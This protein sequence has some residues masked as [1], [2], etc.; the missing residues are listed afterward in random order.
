MSIRCD[1]Q[2]LL[3]YH[4]SALRARLRRR[5]R[6]ADVVLRKRLRMTASRVCWAVLE[7]DLERGRRWLRGSAV[8]RGASAVIPR[9]RAS[10]SCSY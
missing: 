1:I 7:V 9:R 3:F 10:A 2:A 5:R 4:V 6:V 8:P